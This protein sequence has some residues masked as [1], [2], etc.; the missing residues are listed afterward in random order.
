MSESTEHDEAYA[1]TL[2]RVREVFHDVQLCRQEQS[3]LSVLLTKAIKRNAPDP[4]P[5][6]EIEGIHE[7]LGDLWSPAFNLIN[8]D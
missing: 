8:G 1:I 3:N 4:V 7:L 5:T 2:A 6:I